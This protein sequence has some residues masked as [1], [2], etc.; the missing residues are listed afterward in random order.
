MRLDRYIGEKPKFLV[1][2]RID[3]LAHEDEKGVIVADDG[4]LYRE[5]PAF[6][7]FV[8][9]LKDWFTPTALI[10]YAQAARHSGDH[11]LAADVMR[12]AGEASRRPDRKIPD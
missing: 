3:G 7:Y 8:L 6:D 10:E 9:A 11:A 1:F 4:T 12:L 2:R 5:V